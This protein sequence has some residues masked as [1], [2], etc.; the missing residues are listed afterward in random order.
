MLEEQ[1]S[2]A[3][4]LWVVVTCGILSLLGLGIATYLTIAHYVG[5]QALACPSNGLINCAKVTTSAQSVILGIPVAVLGLGFYL[6]CT[7]LFSPWSWHSQRRELRIAQLV[8]VCTGMAFV[9]WLVA[10][11]LLIIKSICEWCTAEHLVTFA[12]FVVVLT[13]VPKLLSAPD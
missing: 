1:R 4:A 6:A 10:A 12:L 13:T 8:A 5:T 2:A 9:L 11:E 3:A 7:A